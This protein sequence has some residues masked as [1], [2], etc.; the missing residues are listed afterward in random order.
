MKKTTTRLATT[1]AVLVMSAFAI[2]L[3]QHDARK[4]S[5][6]EE[7]ISMHHA[8]SE[9]P[10][11]LAVDNWPSD[12]AVIRG[13]NDSPLDATLTAYENPLRETEDV[14]EPNDLASAAANLFGPSVITASGESTFVQ[15]KV[16]TPRTDNTSAPTLQPLPT[17]MSDGFPSLSGLAAPGTGTGTS[18]ATLNNP[19]SAA[20]ALPGNSNS[21][22]NSLPNTLPNTLPPASARLSDSSPGSGGLGTLPNN[23]RSGSGLPGTQPSASAAPNTTA[24]SNPTSSRGQPGA[25]RLGVPSA[26]PPSAPP[27]SISPASIS[28]GNNASAY[29]S[30][31]WPP[32]SS[33]TASMSD[34]Q[35]GAMVPTQ[36]PGNSASAPNIN[37]GNAGFNSAGF[38]GAGYSSAGS[39][40]AT[41]G[42]T[43]SAS[44]P[45]A[46]T[47]STPKSQFNNQPNYDNLGNAGRAAMTDLPSAPPAAFAGGNLPPQ[48]NY[49]ASRSF[50][51]TPSLGGA[52][53]GSLASSSGV[54]GNVA[55]QPA[56]QQGMAQQA[57]AQQGSLGGFGPSSAP[58]S[59]E[60]NRMTAT[61]NGSMGSDFDGSAMGART[62]LVSNQPGSR[63]LDGSQNPVMQIQKRAPEEIT[64]GKKTSFAI[65]V[66]NAGNAAAHDVTVLDRI[67]RGARFAEA[68]PNVNPTADGLLVWKLGEMGPGD[69]KTINLQIIPEIEGE[70]GSVASV[71]FAA[72]ASVR[73]MATAPQLDLQVDSPSPVVIGQGQM[74]AV[75]IRNTG[76]GVARGIRLEADIPAQ[77]KHES[78][79][80]QLEAAL[81]DLRPG[82]SQRLT[83]NVAAVQPG[84]SVC[85]LRAINEDGIQAQNQFNVDV[86]APQLQATIAGPA[87][88]YL[89][90]Q[91][92]YQVVISNTGT[93]MA[94]NLFFDVH[95]PVGL[96]FVSADI[97]QATYHPETHSVT[98]GLAEL[99]A[100]AKATF[101]VSVLP[102]ELG[103]QG[104]R[105]SATGDLGISAE[106]KGQ[107]VVEGLSELAF[108][109]GQDNGTVEVGATTTYAVQVSNVGNQSDK[110][111]QLQIQ[112]P[113]GAKLL[114]VDAPVDHRDEPGRLTFAAVGKCAVAT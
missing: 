55:Q 57:A 41:S 48:E 60:S 99:N 91:A 15:D 27:T 62:S 74:I 69:E 16:A 28:G 75:T 18:P 65:I 76:T 84:Q 50:S 68:S 51:D 102:V 5:Q 56:V 23:A 78:G 52:S 96:K 71:H 87:R 32:A 79:E 10:M 109:I 37:A 83:L 7:S 30:A 112:L 93:A 110:N 26:P 85:P 9:P 114:K 95:L 25:A 39:G 64:V 89:E 38:N 67:P 82:E 47:N 63:F 4:T 1:T 49:S 2:L 111:V 106:A 66:R 81:G 45:S 21:Q 19:A 44:Q 107:V 33:S 80:N 54:N 17:S 104:I 11:P 105:I 53:S 8:P 70:V 77:L 36:F 98:L 14:Q 101:A 31:A 73:S 108:T 20:S 59:L 22:F 43:S 58:R 113:E 42:N 97:A 35:R 100:G 3:A 6:V 29:G 103:P 86:R 94:Q 88:R 13:N 12:S 92:T 46:Q 61:S 34:T 90:R 40:S 24:N 72:Q